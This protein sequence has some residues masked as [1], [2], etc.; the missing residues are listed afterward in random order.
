M[1][2][3]HLQIIYLI[4]GPICRKRAARTDDPDFLLGV[5][6]VEENGDKRVRMA[7]LAFVGCACVN[8]V[9]ALHTDLMRQTVFRD[10]RGRPRRDRQQDQRHHF[11]ALALSR[12][13]RRSPSC[14]SPRSATRVLDDP[15]RLLEL[16]AA[17][18]RRRA[19]F[20]RFRPARRVTR[21]LARALRRRDRRPRSTR[22]ALFDVHIKR[23]HEYKRQLLNILETIALYKAMRAQPQRDRVPRVKIFAGKAAAATTARS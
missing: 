11:P 21:R 5:S 16:G 22:D 15:G 4:N 12:P 3:R 6:L 18:R 19:S 7:H 13:T 20:G 23:I 9:S 14:W 1:L 2:P 17:R 8:G 10:L